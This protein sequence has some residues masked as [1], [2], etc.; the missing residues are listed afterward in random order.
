MLGGGLELMIAQQAEGCAGGAAWRQLTNTNLGLDLNSNNKRL[1]ISSETI[2]HSS[3]WGML[4]LKVL[5]ML[6]QIKH[7]IKT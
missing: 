5:N 6:L 2:C 3:Q 1:S 4:S 7:P